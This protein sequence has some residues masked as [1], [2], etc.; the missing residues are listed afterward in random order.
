MIKLQKLI[1][2]KAIQS[3]KHQRMAEQMQKTI[4]DLKVLANKL[5][6]EISADEART[7]NYDPNHIAYPTF[8]KAAVQRRNNLLNSIDELTIQLDNTKNFIR[9]TDEEIKDAML[10]VEQDRIPE[11]A[12]H[13]GVA[14]QLS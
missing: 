13:V 3:E 10:L 9:E 1:Q 4:A 11:R 7:Q 12:D 6:L 14:V 8:A 5:K 2:R